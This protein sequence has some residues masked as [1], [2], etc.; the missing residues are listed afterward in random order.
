MT[1]MWAPRRQAQGPFAITSQLSV[2]PM[3]NGPKHPLWICRPVH[4]M[5]DGSCNACAAIEDREERRLAALRVKVRRPEGSPTHC[6]TVNQIARVPRSGP[7]TWHG[8]KVFVVG[9][10]ERDRERSRSRTSKTRRRHKA[11]TVLAMEPNAVWLA[12]SAFR[13]A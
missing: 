2:S 7:K 13:V 6:A 3:R 4:C 11:W 12:A 8:G 1:I 9:L 10:F 5:R